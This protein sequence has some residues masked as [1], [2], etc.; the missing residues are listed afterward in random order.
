MENLDEDS[1][2]I[3]HEL[4]ENELTAPELAERTHL[5][6]GQVHYRL[7]NKLSDRVTQ[8]D[9]KENPGAA[10]DTTV[11]TV[12][13]EVGEIEDLPET[14][15]SISKRASEASKEAKSAKESVQAYRK[16]VN[17]VKKRQDALKSAIGASWDDM[18][19]ENILTGR[20]FREIDG[21]INGVKDSFQQH[22]A[23]LDDELQVE[24]N[25]YRKS[26]KQERREL[27]NELSEI[28]NHI[29]KIET[30]LD[31]Q[32]EAV[33]SRLRRLE[34]RVDTL[35]KRTLRDFLPF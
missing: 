17:R 18:S 33:N 31:E 23:D 24:I 22:L 1:I 20:Q 21:R 32:E 16:K 12:S 7:K 28:K 29:D 26:S 35:E 13:D 9:I 25:D 8:T 14:F 19:D 10:G 27:H 2:R 30:R 11:W 15:S 3:L 4:S 6:R 5:S 34:E